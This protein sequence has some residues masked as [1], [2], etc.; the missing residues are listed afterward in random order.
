M[1]CECWQVKWG[2]G[3][4]ALLW[5]SERGHADTV[6]VLVEL[7][8]S[9]EAVDKVNTHAHALANTCC[10]KHVS[11]IMRMTMII[12]SHAYAYV[13][14]YIHSYVLY[15]YSYVC[16]HTYIY[17]N[18]YTYIHKYIQMYKSMYAHRTHD[19]HRHPH[20]PRHMLDTARVCEGM[21]VYVYLV[22]GL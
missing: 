10:I 4:T 9:V 17:M 15:V 3:K 22:D 21:R 8:A 5:A 12:M 2:Y 13:Y 6:R 19:D 11:G 1:T 7:G 18:I 16:M 20:N 14:V